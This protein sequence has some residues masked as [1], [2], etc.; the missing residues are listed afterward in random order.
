MG[1]VQ[2]LYTG[3]P[4]NEGEILHAGWLLVCRDTPEEAKNA[5]SGRI[6]RA[7]GGAGQIWLVVDGRVMWRVEENKLEV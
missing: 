3:M 4:M 2:Y 7:Y 1:V 5:R 6:L